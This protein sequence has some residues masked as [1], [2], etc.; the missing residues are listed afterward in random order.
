MVKLIVKSIKQVSNSPLLTEQLKH[1]LAVEILYDYPATDPLANILTSFELLLRGKLIQPCRQ[2]LLKILNFNTITTTIK[3]ITT[4]NETKTNSKYIISILGQ[5]VMQIMS[6][7]NEEQ[8][9]K[10]KEKAPKQDL[11]TKENENKHYEFIKDD[12]K[13]NKD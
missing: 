10:P 4:T 11:N 5:L 13:L 7:R 3:C 8:S 6:G 12:E 1:Q 9:S 2:V